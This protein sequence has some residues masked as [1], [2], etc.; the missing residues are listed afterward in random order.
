[1]KE[2]KARIRVVVRNDLG[3]VMGS[4]VEK[5]EKPSTMEVLEA[6]ATRKAM[7]FM[8]ELGLRQAIFEGDLE[9]VVK[10]LVGDCPVRSSIRHI[11]KDCKSL[12][13]LF[14]TYTFSQVRPQSNG[15]AHAL[16]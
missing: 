12:M 15:V 3:Q 6:L 14:Q 10:A 7:I 13:G 2:D 8:V 9:I 16:A 11:V 4:L 5:I 1:M